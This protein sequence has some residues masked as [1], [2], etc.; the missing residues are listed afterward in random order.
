MK[1]LAFD[2]SLGSTSV[3]VS[4]GQDILAYIE[5]NNLSVQA[6]RLV[7][8]IEQALAGAGLS[9]KEI[10]Y[11][12]VINGPGSF[13]GIRIALAAAQGIL[14]S[15][16]I[17]GCAVT[18]F[19]IAAYRTRLQIEEADKIVVY[20]NAY[21]NQLYVQIFD[22]DGS[23]FLAPT[24]IDIERAGSML[25]RLEGKIICTGNGIP[26]IYNQLKE[27]KEILVLPRFSKIRA[28][29]VCRYVDL[30]LRGGF[31]LNAI[32]PLYI[33]PPDAVVK[34]GRE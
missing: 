23:V 29:H 11:L 13:T 2:T 6:E 9:Y 7:P 10:D 12:S 8:M 25:D 24:L 19:E 17:K 16:D 5:D 21:R 32:E 15:T 31:P 22:S 30:S 27:H 18:N 14:L 3:A 1:I 20:L 33:R 28:F 34:P 4:N 26:L